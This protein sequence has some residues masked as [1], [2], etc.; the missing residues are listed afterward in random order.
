MLVQVRHFVRDL[1]IHPAAVAVDNP[2]LEGSTGLGHARLSILDLDGGAQP[3][4]NAEQSIWITFNGEIFNYLELRD[5]L[6]KTGHVFRTSSDTEVIL[7]LYE[8]KGEDCVK[9]MN[10][11]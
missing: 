8:K 9:F 7:A 2:H 5:E 1:H 3:M 11:D 6:R 10:G 4:S